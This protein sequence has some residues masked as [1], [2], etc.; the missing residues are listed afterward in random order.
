MAG[1]TV[2]GQAGTHTLTINDTSGTGAAGTVSLNGGPAVAFAS[3]E[4]DLKVTGPAG[5]V[6]YLNTSSI[7]AGFNGDVDITATGTISLDGGATAVA[8]DY[9]SN[10]TLTNDSLGVVQ[11][12]DTTGV[13]RA[14]E[15]PVE[16][17]D[18]PDVFATLRALRDDLRN[19]RGLSNSELD[20][21]FNRRIGD[22]DLAQDHLLGVIGEQAVSLTQLQSIQTRLEDLKLGA[23]ELLGDT[24]STDLPSAILKLQEE[25]N[26]LQ[27]T[28]S[29]L[30]TLT[31]TT[32]LDFL[33]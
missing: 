21:A 14:G 19:T 10:Q 22:L 33:R 25:Q 30:V 31:N 6:V 12:F 29:S 20:D 4:T 24:E 8:I 7:S 23:Q 13:T 11:H 27:F 28:L 18:N 5:E 1:D 26:L 17:A 32:V 16:F 9:S 15:A 2:I 3:S